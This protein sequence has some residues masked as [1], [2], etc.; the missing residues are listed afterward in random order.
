MNVPDFTP[1]Q[2]IKALQK[3]GF[4]IEKHTG[5]GGHFKAKAPKGTGVSVGRRNFIIIPYHS[6]FKNRFFVIDELR[7]FGIDIE[8]FIDAL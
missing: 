2:C 6:K 1:R 7:A 4:K 3:L 8:R 5:R